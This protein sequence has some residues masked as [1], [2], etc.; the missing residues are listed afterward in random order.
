MNERAE[1]F[2]QELKDIESTMVVMMAVRVTV[3][4]RRRVGWKRAAGLFLAV[5]AHL[6]LWVTALGLMHAGLN[7]PGGHDNVTTEFFM[8]LAMFLGYAIVMVAIKDEP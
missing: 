5:A 6:A 8:G 2:L 4:L 3:A 7:S 1:K